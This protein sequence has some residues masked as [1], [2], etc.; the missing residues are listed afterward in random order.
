M[1]LRAIPLILTLTLAGCSTPASASTAPV[2]DGSLRA[3]TYSWMQ[4]GLDCQV[5]ALNNVVFQITGARMSETRVVAYAESSGMYNPATGSQPY[6]A[7]S[8]LAH[9]GVASSMGSHTISTIEADLRAG[10]AVMAFV[11]AEKL[12]NTLSAATTAGYTWGADTNSPDHALVVDEIDETNRTVTLTDS[13]TAHG[14][15]EVVPLS[16]FQASVATSGWEY[17]V[18]PL[19]TGQH[20]AG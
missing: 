12:W 13:G 15:A 11:D 2:V 17:V 20:R 8:F 10:S 18:A 9:Y 4:H 3:S 14:A 1:Q 5:M 19:P 16:V 7:T 6:L